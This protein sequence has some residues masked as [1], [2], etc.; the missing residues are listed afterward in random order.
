MRPCKHWHVDGFMHRP[1]LECRVEV[2]ELQLAKA[3]PLLTPGNRL[4][5][6]MAAH[7]YDRNPADTTGAKG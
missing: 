6:E 2:L 7:D 5:V 4:A 3:L 1:C